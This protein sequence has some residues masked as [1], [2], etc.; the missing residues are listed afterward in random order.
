MPPNTAAWPFGIISN[1]RTGRSRFPF[2]RPPLCSPGALFS[3]KTN[4]LLHGLSPGDPWRRPVRPGRLDAGGSDEAAGLLLDQGEGGA[5]QT[6]APYP[7]RLHH[8]PHRFRSRPV[9]AQCVSSMTRSHTSPGPTSS[10]AYGL[11]LFL[12]PL[13]SASPARAIDWFRSARKN[14]GPNRQT[15]PDGE[16]SV[17]K[18]DARIKDNTR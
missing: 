8:A 5:G 18:P 11:W 16:S 7:R 14:A 13:A 17:G 3:A 9:P 10:T 1:S 15:P 6:P 2:R 12:S 4:S